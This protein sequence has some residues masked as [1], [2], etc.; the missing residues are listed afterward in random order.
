MDY[1]VPVPPTRNWRAA[2][3][4]AATVAGVELLVLLV[5][6]A[7]AIA[8]PW[9]DEAAGHAERATKAAA[10]PAEKPTAAEPKQHH[11]AAA[12]ILPRSRTSVVVLNGNGIP[13]AADEESG[14][15][16][17]LRYVVAGTA[18]APRS[19]FAR[20]LVMYRPRFRAEAERLAKDLHVRRV[21]PLDGMRAR[22]LMGAQV[23]LIL[24]GS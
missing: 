14:R 17:T 11:A 20:T 12:T 5:I 13:G 22:D 21:A 15:V 2:A 10:A 19:D 18:N 4:V 7:A 3:L 6:G 23:A 1:P 24:G 8:R 9:A 16:R